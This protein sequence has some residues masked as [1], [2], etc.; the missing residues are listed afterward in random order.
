MYVLCV[1]KYTDSCLCHIDNT[2][3]SNMITL[4]IIILIN[5][6]TIYSI[7]MINHAWLSGYNT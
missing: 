3:V 6:T 1:C 7:N 2:I 5:M 4:G